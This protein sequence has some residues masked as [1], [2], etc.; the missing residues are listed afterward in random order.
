MNK[1]Q[2]R[3]LSIYLG[4]VLGLLLSIFFT[5]SC[6]TTVPTTKIDYCKPKKEKHPGMVEPEYKYYKPTKKK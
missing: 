5:V 4:I 2:K 6:T 3:L 1:I